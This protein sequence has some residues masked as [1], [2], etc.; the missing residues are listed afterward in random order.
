MPVSELGAKYVQETRDLADSIETY[1][2]IVS[3]LSRVLVLVVLVLVG[4][5]LGRRVTCRLATQLSPW[6]QL[7]RRASWRRENCSDRQFPTLITLSIP[8]LSMHLMP[9]IT[10]NPCFTLSL[11]F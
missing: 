1:I 6:S 5:G 11:F 10:H 2:T 8:S 3:V 4:V 9:H 7:S